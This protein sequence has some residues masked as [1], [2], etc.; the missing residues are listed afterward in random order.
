M[1]HLQTERIHISYICQRWF[2]VCD[3]TLILFLMQFE[4]EEME[5][6]DEEVGNTIFSTI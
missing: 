4:E 5:E 3:F 6:G 2:T 1:G